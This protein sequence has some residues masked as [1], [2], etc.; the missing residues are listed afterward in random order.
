MKKITIEIEMENEAFVEADKKNYR[1]DIVALASRLTKPGDDR[2]HRALLEGAPNHISA[3]EVLQI[4]DWWADEAHTV[5]NTTEAEGREIARALEEIVRV[6]KGLPYEG[7]A[8]EI[9]EDED[10][11]DA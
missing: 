9:D 3:D 10:E 8:Y 1:N 5:T 2:W 6:N 4:A 7:T 11:G